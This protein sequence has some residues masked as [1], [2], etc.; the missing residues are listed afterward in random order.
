MADVPTSR[1]GKLSQGRIDHE[2]KGEEED[3]EVGGDGHRPVLLGEEVE[4]DGGEDGGGEHRPAEVEEEEGEGEE[5][6]DE[7]V[8][9]TT[10]GRC[11]AVLG[12]S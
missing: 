12:H 3:G 11:R 7:A 4:P 8:N 6:E 5:V 2:D 10:R 9:C 1:G